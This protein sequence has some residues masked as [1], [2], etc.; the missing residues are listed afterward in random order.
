MTKTDGYRRISS[1]Q[2]KK[3]TPFVYFLAV[4]ALRSL[5]ECR[6]SMG[7]VRS[8]YLPHL[9]QQLINGYYADDSL[10][11]IR[12]EDSNAKNTLDTI[13]VLCDAL[14]A[15]IQWRKSCCYAQPL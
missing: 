12:L 7:H 15:K 11:T 3:L 1:E 2:Q 5:V 6:E 14:G 9:N 4:D 13:Q 8:I 10:L